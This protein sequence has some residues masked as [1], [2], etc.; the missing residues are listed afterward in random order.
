MPLTNYSLFFNYSS[1]NSYMDI[2]DKIQIH[3]PDSIDSEYEKCTDP[4][5]HSRSILEKVDDSESSL[6]SSRYVRYSVYYTQIKVNTQSN[7]AKP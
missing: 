2:I 3:S 5:W 7:I 1:K 6:N 4:L